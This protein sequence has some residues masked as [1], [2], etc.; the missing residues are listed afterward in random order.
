MKRDVLLK[1]EA[2]ILF[3]LIVWGM[4]VS[5]RSGWQAIVG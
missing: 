4:V 2:A 5:V 3:A 1:L